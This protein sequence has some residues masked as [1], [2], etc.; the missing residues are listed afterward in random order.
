MTYITGL[1]TKIN[2][3]L[4]SI[5][6]TP[7]SPPLTEGTAGSLAPPPEAARFVP[8]GVHWFA[9]EVAYSFTLCNNLT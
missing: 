7:S 8:K 4:A 6:N 3:K 2:D 5:G 1:H 9:A